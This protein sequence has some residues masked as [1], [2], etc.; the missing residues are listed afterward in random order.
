MMRTVST[1]SMLG[2]SNLVK[3]PIEVMES[4]FVCSSMRSKIY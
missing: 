4:S 1:N 3:I 2:S